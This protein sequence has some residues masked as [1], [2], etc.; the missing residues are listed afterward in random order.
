MQRYLQADLLRK[1]NLAHFDAW[2][3]SFAEKITK[4]EFAPEGT[5]FGRKQGLQDSITCLSL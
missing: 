4:L 3:A 1:N 5:G 2:A